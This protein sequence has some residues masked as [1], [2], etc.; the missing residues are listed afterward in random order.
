MPRNKLRATQVQAATKP[1]VLG[2][3]EGLYLRVSPSGA[4]FW[5]FVWRRRGR[6]REIGLGGTGN[7]S[8]AMAREKANEARAILGRGGDPATEMAERRAALQRRTFGECADDLIVSM[9]SGWRH[10]KSEQQWRMTLT[11]YAKPLRGLAVA[12]VTTDD[13]IQTLKPIWT[14][15][16]E[17]A[18]R[19]RG[20][21][22]KVLDHAKTRGLRVGENP[23]RWRGHLA[24]LLPARQKLARRTTLPCRT[25]KC[26]AS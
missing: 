7:V 24:L 13:V 25:A 1:G 6:R 17:T 19:T 9:Q 12:D 5:I 3:G 18:S 2:D 22:E 21:I 16:P 15:K 20:C 8:L 10:N 11:E 23:A 4:K 26:R 14:A